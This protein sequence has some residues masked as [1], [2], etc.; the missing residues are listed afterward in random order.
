MYKKILRLSIPNI[1]TNI[2]VPLL[3]MVD[4]AIVGH[5]GD[6]KYIGAIAIGTAIF[7]LIY[8][9]FGF[10]RMGTSGF[11]AQAFGARNLEECMHVL[12]RALSVAV[13]VAIL[14]LA[15]QLF[16]GKI[17]M[18]FMHAEGVMKRLAL[19]YFFVRIWAAPATLSLYVFKG[20]FI[21]MQNS[22]TPMYIAITINIVNIVF[23]LL[24]VTVFRLGIEGVAWGTVIA[25][26]SGVLFSV[27]AWL[28]YYGRLSRYFSIR[29]SLDWNCLLRFFHIN[30]DIFLRTL[31]LVIVF[32]FFTSASSGMGEMVLAVNTLFMQ[33]FIL[34]SYIMDG[35]AYAGEALVGRYVGAENR[36]MLQKSVKHI[37]VW[38]AGIAIL[39]T[40]IYL[41]FL[42][43]LLSLFTNNDVIVE[44]ARE[45]QEWIVA[46]PLAGFL[47]FVYD[48]VLVGATQAG[49]MRNVMFVATVF[50]F[51]IYYGFY[52]LMGNEALWC[53]FIVYL[54][55]RG[56]MQFILSRKIIFSK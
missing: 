19:D 1:I 40:V 52:P 14:V 41:F 31:C 8:W 48:G 36:R 16:I 27:I 53:A 6:E 21:G 33:M 4:L 28:K 55:V 44:T 43:P 23:S 42:E 7:N 12:V 25:Q 10:L 15:L 11:A 18:G 20:W 35:F 32:T 54:L 46:V 34:F 39:F 5:L 29:R 49:I 38:G 51:A 45:S 17:A 56:I 30:G 50:F 47:A 24:F 9:N 2:T 3:G 13:S 22:R 26:F 37:I